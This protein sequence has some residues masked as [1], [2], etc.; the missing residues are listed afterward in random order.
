MKKL[1]YSL[2][3]SL[4]AL[5]L[6]ASLNIPG[7]PAKPSY[8]VTG[9][10]DIGEPTTIDGVVA[11]LTKLRNLSDEML[12]TLRLNEG[13]KGP[14]VDEAALKK[15]GIAYLAK[16]KDINDKAAWYDSLGKNIEKP[17]LNQADYKKHYKQ[18]VEIYDLVKAIK[19]NYAEAQTFIK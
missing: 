18:R 19:A 15:Q 5:S 10:I 12:I 11:E 9:P 13:R 7:I 17:E 2:I 3:L 16:L 4:Y 14:G 6:Q 1:L 8:P